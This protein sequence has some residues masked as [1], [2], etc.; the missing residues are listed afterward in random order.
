MKSIQEP[1]KRHSDQQG[2]A[3]GAGE[4][5][6]LGNQFA[7][8]D[9]QGAQERKRAGQRGGVGNQRSAGSRSARPDGLKCFRKR[10]FAERTDRQARQGDPKL[11]AGDYAVQVRQQNFHNARTDVAFGNQLSHA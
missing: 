11:H 7:D 8:D 6:R 4:A 1:L 2:D 3:F 9:V 10:C 5:Y